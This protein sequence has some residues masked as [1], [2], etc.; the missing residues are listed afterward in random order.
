MGNFMKVVFVDP[1]FE[2]YKQ[3]GSF[4]D[5]NFHVFENIGEGD[6]VK[7]GQYP[8]LEAAKEDINDWLKEMER[9]SGL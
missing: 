2:V 3:E 4:A 6:H 9:N 5:P 1:P 8:T 7:A